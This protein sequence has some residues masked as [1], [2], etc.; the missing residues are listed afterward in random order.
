MQRRGEGGREKKSGLPGAITPIDHVQ[1]ALTGIKWTDTK[2]IQ[3][4]AETVLHVW[5]YTNVH[6]S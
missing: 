2:D 1:T 5:N 4:C 6:G 3:A